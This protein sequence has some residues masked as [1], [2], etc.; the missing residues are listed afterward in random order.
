MVQDRD[1][2]RMRKPQHSG[3]G[4]NSDPLQGAIV[5]H[6][7]E[8][9]YLIIDKPAGLP[10]HSTVDN[11]L[12]NVAAAAGRS[13]LKS[14]KDYLRKELKEGVKPK[15]PS[16]KK[17]KKEALI[18]VATPQRLDQSTSGLLVIATKKIFASYFAKLLRKKTDIQLRQSEEN[19]MPEQVGAVNK[20]Y[21]CL[22]CVI[23]KRINGEVTSMW[24]E[25]DELRSYVESQ[26]IVRHYLEQ[27]KRSPRLFVP[28]PDLDKKSSWLECLM[29]ISKVGD[30]YPVIG[31]TASSTL[32]K[33]LWSS[34]GAF[35]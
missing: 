13:I 33:A 1:W 32:S 8:K 10:V 17:E 30:T 25:I 28:T 23:P 31:N 26:S 21:R 22:V 5:H 27:S 4:T 7:L 14:E 2:G 20:R 16:F 35:H 9:G 3:K 24:D 29:K 12:E 11:I 18:Y 15:E 34:E 19:Y 6:D